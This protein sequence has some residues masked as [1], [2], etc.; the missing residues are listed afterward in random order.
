MLAIS[1]LSARNTE[2]MKK[3]PSSDSE[4][5]TCIYSFIRGRVKKKIVEFLLRWVGG[6][7]SGLIFRYSFIFFIFRYGL[8]ILDFA[9]RSF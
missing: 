6:V 2:K 4:A 7:S 5:A 1:F 3:R 9:Y 8:K